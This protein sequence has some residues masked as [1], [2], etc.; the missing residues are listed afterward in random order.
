MN[1]QNSSRALCFRK[2][3]G[4]NHDQAEY[5][6]KTQAGRTSNGEAIRCR[7]HDH[8]DKSKIK[9]SAWMDNLIRWRDDSIAKRRICYPLPIGTFIERSKY[10]KK[11]NHQAKCI[12]CFFKCGESYRNN[13]GEFREKYRHPARKMRHRP[14]STDI[15]SSI[16][17]SQKSFQERGNAIGALIIVWAVDR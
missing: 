10:R 6:R 3:E 12:L 2:A 1:N 16:R 15:G 11:E 7:A 4:R 17:E 5:R 9:N 14:R 8:K 13:F